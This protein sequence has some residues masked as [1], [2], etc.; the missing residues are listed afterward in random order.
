MST[1]PPAS[2]EPSGTDSHDS[3]NSLNMNQSHSSVCTAR[4]LTD[5]PYGADIPLFRRSDLEIGALLGRGRFSQVHAIHRIRKSSNCSDGTPS[6]AAVTKEHCCYVIKHI[7]SKL[8]ANRGNRRGAKD[9]TNAIA[10]LV[11]EAMYLCKLNHPHIVQIRGLTLG[12]T[13]VLRRK[14]AVGAD[15]FILL[16]RMDETL[17]QRIHWTWRKDYGTATDEKHKYPRQP[18]S[19]VLDKTRYAWQM[20]DALSYL[21]DHQVIYRDLKPENVGFLV[22][23]AVVEP[24]NKCKIQLF[25]F[26]LARE[27]EEPVTNESRLYTLSASGTW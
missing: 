26:G 18:L 25:D 3:V 9:L 21:H 11:T 13:S 8:F 2:C 22:D 16:D 27:L 10:D 4:T 17:D 6:A 14:G 19:L 24:Q 23:T 7:Q 15:Y 1:T 20:A 12:G 5:L